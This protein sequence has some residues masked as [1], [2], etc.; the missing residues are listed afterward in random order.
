MWNLKDFSQRDF[1]RFFKRTLEDYNLEYRRLCPRSL[2]GSDRVFG[3]KTFPRTFADYNRR[4]R[5]KIFSKGSWGLRGRYLKTFP[6]TFEVFFLRFL[7]RN[8][9]DYNR[10]I[11]K[12]SWGHQGL[13]RTSRT[14]EDYKYNSQK[15]L[16]NYSCGFL[17]FFVNYIWELVSWIFKGLLKTPR[18]LEKSKNSWRLQSRYFKGVLRIPRTLNH[19]KDFWQIL[20]HLRTTIGD[21]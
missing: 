2:E 7:P 9:K 17:T 21:F 13:L 6:R 10:G 20:G 3:K 11:L 12:D 18:N 19:S 5:L 1:W 8:F 14:H 15:T 16:E 4:H